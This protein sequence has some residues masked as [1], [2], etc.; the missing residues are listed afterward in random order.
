[1]TKIWDPACSLPQPRWGLS[2]KGGGRGPRH[3]CRLVLK[4]GFGASRLEDLD[5]V[6]GSIGDVNPPGRLVDDDAVKVAELAFAGALLTPHGQELAV[7]IENLNAIVTDLRDINVIV[8]VDGNAGGCL[9]FAFAGT[10]LAPGA[11][12]LAV[13]V[14]DLDPVVLEIGDVELAGAVELRG[15]GIVHLAR[16]ATFATEVE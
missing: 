1:M 6:V 7:L 14:E 16:L 3:D 5:A 13:F 15:L 11:D 12:R 9:E 4:L 10:S 8:G 2:F